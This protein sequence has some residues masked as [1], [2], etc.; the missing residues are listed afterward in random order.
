MIV[1]TPYRPQ[2]PVSESH[3][4]L[5]AFDWLDAIRM[6]AASVRQSCRCPTVALSSADLPV[7]TFRYATESQH[8]M[9]WILEICL[10]YLESGDF[11]EDTV[12]ISPDM[13]VFRDLS[14]W[15][16]ADLCLL[17]RTA[18]KYQRRPLLNGV[19]WWRRHA[20]ASLIA[21]YRE[22]W[23]RS[24]ALPE[25]LQIWGGDTEPL[26]ALAPTVT[27]GEARVGDL[28]IVGIP[29]ED[30]IQSVSRVEEI[31]LAHRQPIARPS[32]AVVDFRYLRK[33]A[34][35]AYFD[36]TIGAGEAA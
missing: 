10:R 23:R 7:S 3:R 26:L 1:V 27:S 19:Q 6:L 36:A 14:P 16:S 11:R 12:M 28:S 24:L 32:K 4:R 21:F 15:F 30:V 25:A 13:L 34:M 17:V 5:G 29:H 20:K 22:A 9:P 35:R 33:K 2:A 31:A 8:L 18:P